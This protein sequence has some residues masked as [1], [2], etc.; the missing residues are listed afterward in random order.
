MKAMSE[1]RMSTN[2]S[3]LGALDT[4]GQLGTTTSQSQFTENPLLT[5]NKTS[6]SQEFL[7]VPK[8]KFAKNQMLTPGS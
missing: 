5:D 6:S 8:S 1:S 2:G 4:R 3:H 7:S